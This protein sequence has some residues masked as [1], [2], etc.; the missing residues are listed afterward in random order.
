MSVCS[1][2]LK[3]IEWNLQSIDAKL[4]DH[5]FRRRWQNV[6]YA[7]SV[8]LHAEQSDARQIRFDLSTQ[9][10]DRLEIA[11]P[12]SSDLWHL[13]G[14]VFN[15]HSAIRYGIYDFNF[16]LC[17]H[18]ISNFIKI[19]S[20]KSL[21]GCQTFIWHRMFERS[22]W[23]SQSKRAAIVDCKHVPYSQQSIKFLHHWRNPKQRLSFFVSLQS[24]RVPTTFRNNWFDFLLFFSFVCKNILK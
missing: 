16:L 23:F 12:S 3:W 4:L 18:Q 5:S 15:R 6:L 2:I 14:D 24:F 22:I 21:I 20:W 8:G 19:I 11:A 10:V 9:P 17:Q 7:W 1:H 13:F